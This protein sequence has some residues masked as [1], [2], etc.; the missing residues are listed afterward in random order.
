METL[1]IFD[2]LSTADI[3]FQS[4]DVSEVQEDRHNEQSSQGDHFVLRSSPVLLF[5][6][7][8][9]QSEKSR[10][11]KIVQRERGFTTEWREKVFGMLFPNSSHQE[12]SGKKE[13]NDAILELPQVWAVFEKGLSSVFPRNSFESYARVQIF[14]VKFFVPT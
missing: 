7:S 1:A 13:D 6:G 4:V 14:K 5:S 12:S 11:R 9:D 10:W 8:D 2:T 3:R